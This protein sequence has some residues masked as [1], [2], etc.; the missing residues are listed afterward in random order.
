[1][2]Q[3]L[4]TP[5][6][7]DADRPAVAAP[8]PGATESLIEEVRQRARRRRLNT[9]GVIGIAAL[10]LAGALAIVSRNGG[11]NPPPSVAFEGA[12][13][14]GVTPITTPAFTVTRGGVTVLQWSD[15]PVLQKPPHGRP[16]AEAGALTVEIVNAS[17]RVLVNTGALPGVIAGRPEVVTATSVQSVSE[18][19]SA[20]PSGSVALT[21][22]PGRYRL[23]VTANGPWRIGVAKLDNAQPVQL[24]HTWTGSG[25]AVIGPFVGGTSLQVAAREGTGGRAGGSV[26]TVGG[27][28]FDAELFSAPS[29][30]GLSIVLEEKAPYSGKAPRAVDLPGGPYVLGVYAQGT[31]SITVSSSTT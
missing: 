31:W 4:D 1:V 7:T 9:A 18:N 29:G 11:H 17:T 10:V 27:S 16:F 12:A 3:L 24:P 13:S 20:P 5:W 21:L 2:T 8:R 6:R 14:Q 22:D 30:R 23:L 15:P 25:P 19:V 28:A 26:T